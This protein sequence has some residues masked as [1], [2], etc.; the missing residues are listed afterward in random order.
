MAPDPGFAGLREGENLG[1]KI[2]TGRRFSPGNGPP[3]R[4]PPEGAAEPS[5]SWTERPSLKGTAPSGR[6]GRVG[7]A[8][9]ALKR[10]AI[11]I[12][13][14]QGGV[15][16]PGA[17]RY[18]LINWAD[19]FPGDP[20]PDDTFDVF[21]SHNSKDKPAVRQI[22]EALRD[23]GLRVW[24]DEWELIPGRRWIPALEKA[25]QAA[26]RLPSWWAKTASAPGSSP[27]TKAPCPSSWAGDFP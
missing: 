13:P 5:L 21:L 23:R 22:A 18:L 9:P 12:S 10:R 4:R 20:L 27:N 14:F 16:F 7:T 11:Q 6:M 2:K 15:S 24:L 25:I 17:L 19:S 3:T 8:Y 26:K 1:L